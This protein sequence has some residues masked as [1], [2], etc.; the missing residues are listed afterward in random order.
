[1]RNSDSSSE[2]SLGSVFAG[3]VSQAMQS[4]H[5]A[6]L[7]DAAELLVI[8]ATVRAAILYPEW[9][10][11]ILDDPSDELDGLARALVARNSQVL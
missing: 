11:A 1:M 7:L 5:G 4:V 8:R 3:A 2:L 10:L 6:P 9:A